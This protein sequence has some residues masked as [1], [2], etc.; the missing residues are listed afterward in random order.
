MTFRPHEL[1]KAVRIGLLICLVVV[2]IALART[3]IRRNVDA[4]CERNEWP[5]LSACPSTPKSAASQVNELRHRADRNP[6]DAS[7]YLALV[8]LAQQRADIAPINEEDILAMAKVMAGNNPL[9]LRIQASR[10]VASKNWQEAVRVLGR[11]AIQYRDDVALKTMASLVALPEARDALIDG[12]QSGGSWLPNLLRVLPEAKVP[13]V[14]AMPL[15]EAGLS[16]GL[17]KPDAVLDVVGQLKGAGNW[18]EAQALW[19]RLLGRPV[20]MLFNGGFETSFVPGGFDWEVQDGSPNRTGVRIA[21]PTMVDAQGRVLELAFNGRPLTLPVISQVLVLLPGTYAFSGKYMTRRLRAGAG[22]TW[23]FTCSAGKNELGRTVPIKDTKG[24]WQEMNFQVMVPN[25]C[26]AVSMQLQT[27]LRSD[28]LSGLYG[29]AHF[30]E[31]R[32]VAN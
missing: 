24:R 17:L 30:D 2:G 7:S 15:V 3:A 11:L 20:P 28:A 27:E 5:H 13:A 22:L 6:G 4:A 21:Q 14:Q 16:Q 25:A 31:F 19:L 18:L 12:L 23:T 8:L 9:Y 26:G 10:A 32:L 29:D 1:P